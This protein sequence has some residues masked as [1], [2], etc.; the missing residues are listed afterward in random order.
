M[1]LLPKAYFIDNLYMKLVAFRNNNA[2][3]K[4]KIAFFQMCK[5]LNFTYIEC[6]SLDEIPKDTDLIWSDNT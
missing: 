2:H 3:K 6:N 5:E 1:Y 4:N